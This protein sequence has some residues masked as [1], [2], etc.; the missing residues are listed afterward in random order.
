MPFPFEM[1]IWLVNLW[2]Q[3]LCDILTS[4]GCPG[5]ENEHQPFLYFAADDLEYQVGDDAK[6]PMAKYTSI[7][8]P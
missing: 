6:L 1:L 4:G 5:D 2:I 8:T 3:V 7:A